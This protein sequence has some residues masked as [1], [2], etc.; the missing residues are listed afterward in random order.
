MIKSI[1]RG[2][3]LGHTQSRVREH[4]SSK[5][6]GQVLFWMVSQVLAPTQMR[7][8]LVREMRMRYQVVSKMRSPSDL[9]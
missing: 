8:S 9:L 1:L 4:V 7:A 5:M 6:Q 3:V 2:Y